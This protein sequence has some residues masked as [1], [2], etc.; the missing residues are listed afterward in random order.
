MRRVSR[1]KI[2]RIVILCVA[3]FNT[4]CDKYAIYRQY[5]W[6]LIRIVYI[7][8]C[9]MKLLYVIFKIMLIPL[10]NIKCVKAFGLSICPTD[11]LRGL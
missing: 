4:L 5:T 8:V 9:C 7:H 11:S 2:V 3:Y 1:A 10:N 6:L